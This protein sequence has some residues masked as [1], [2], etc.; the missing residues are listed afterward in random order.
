MW[1][2]EQAV[3]MFLPSCC[4]ACGHTKCLM[5]ILHSKQPVLVSILLPPLSASVVPRHSFAHKAQQ[6]CPPPWWPWQPA[7][8]W[9]G[10]WHSCGT[11][12][13]K[14]VFLLA[15]QCCVAVHERLLLYSNMLHAP[16]KSCDGLHFSSPSYHKVQSAQLTC[17]AKSTMG[18]PVHHTKTG[19][20]LL[21]RD[22]IT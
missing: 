7:I 1:G 5:C 14:F 8:I 20:A 3:C 17:S 2:G 18:L 16:G 13:Y 11:D 19:N 12:R 21:S 10:S 15:T 4:C 9:A 22:S 6:D